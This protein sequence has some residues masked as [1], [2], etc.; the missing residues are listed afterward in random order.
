MAAPK[1]KSR[2][3]PLL[4]FEDTVRR[5]TQI[6][7]DDPTRIN[8]WLTQ[9]LDR[10]IPD[11]TL[12]SAEHMIAPHDLWLPVQHYHC[13]LAAYRATFESYKP[14]GPAAEIELSKFCVATLMQPDADKTAFNRYKN[15]AMRDPRLGWTLSVQRFHVVQDPLQRDRSVWTH[16]GRFF[17]HRY[18]FDVDVYSLVMDTR[19]PRPA[20][21][22]S[23][24]SPPSTTTMEEEGDQAGSHD[25]DDDADAEV[26]EVTSSS[27]SESS[28]RPLPTE[29]ERER[30]LEGSTS[31]RNNNSSSFIAVL[32]SRSTSS[33]RSHS[34]SRSK[35]NN[36]SQ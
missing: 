5:A 1:K 13:D 7:F 28:K 2:L 14:Q 34:L 22:P 12:W 20:P 24:L 17:G 35:N 36:N 26:M 32:K 10:E 31:P 33:S 9:R 30:A 3:P 21:D 16:I 15:Y 18:H 25:T 19:L 27:S 11:H 4:P 29:S 6:N 8:T 23:P